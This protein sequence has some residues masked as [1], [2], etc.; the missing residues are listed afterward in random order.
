MTVVLTATMTAMQLWGIKQP[1]REGGKIIGVVMPEGGTA[2]ALIE[3]KDGQ[4]LQGNNGM[5]RPLDSEAVKSALHDEF[6]FLEA[7]LR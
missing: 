2:G 1:I 5:V 3:T 7:A 6:C 4:Y